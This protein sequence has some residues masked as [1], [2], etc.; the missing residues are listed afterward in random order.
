MTLESKSEA[1]VRRLYGDLWSEWRLDVI[2]EILSEMLSFRGS[3]GTVCEGRGATRGA[4]FASF[5]RPSTR[6]EI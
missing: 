4:L 1:V 6:S 3:L 5:L 2:D